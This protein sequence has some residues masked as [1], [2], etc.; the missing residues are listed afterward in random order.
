MREKPELHAAVQPHPRL[1]HRGRPRYPPRVTHDATRRLIPA[2]PNTTT[3]AIL[4]PLF[5][6]TPTPGQ[7]IISSS[8]SGTLDIPT[9]CSWPIYN[10][11]LVT[12]WS[13]QSIVSRE[14]GVSGVVFRWGRRGL[15][16]SE[17]GEEVGLRKA[18]H[19]FWEE[20]HDHHRGVG[21]VDVAKIAV[22]NGHLFH[23]GGQKDAAD[24]RQKR[25][26]SD[27]CC[28]EGPA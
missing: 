12:C 4:S 19:G 25:D 9:L 22:D 8:S 28:K 3:T 18:G 24:R 21:E 27:R 13:Q 17:E 14:D 20:V 7:A 15:A 26:C 23:K 10:N 1:P 16:A 2:T 6:L 11:S 5:L